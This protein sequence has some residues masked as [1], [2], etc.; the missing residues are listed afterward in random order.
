MPIP[1]LMCIHISRRF[2]NHDDRSCSRID[3]LIDLELDDFDTSAFAGS[4]ATCSDCLYKLAAVICHSGSACVGHY[5]TYVR[6]GDSWHCYDDGKEVSLV[7]EEQVKSS[8]QCTMLLYCR[9][10]HYAELIGSSTR[11]NFSGSS[12][13][14]SSSQDLPSTLV[15][16][17]RVTALDVSSHVGSLSSR[18]TPRI[19]DLTDRDADSDDKFDRTES[20]NDECVSRSRS[21]CSALT[22]EKC[23][24]SEGGTCCVC[25]CCFDEDDEVNPLKVIDRSSG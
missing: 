16:T 11:P 17:A 14:L 12:L 1:N 6:D 3:T 19:S 2:Y 8:R 20:D 10:S 23:G 9:K 4:R 13:L 18:S 7:P 22:I 15:D 25:M 24:D 5:W 21:I